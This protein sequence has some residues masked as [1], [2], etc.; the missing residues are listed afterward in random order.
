MLSLALLATFLAI[1]DDMPIPAHSAGRVTADGRFGWPGVYFEGRFTGDDVSVAVETSH[2][3]FRVLIDG[4]ERAT[5]TKAGEARVS[6]TKLGQGEHIVR[7]EKL[8]ESQEG[9]SRFLGFFTRTGHAIARRAANPRQIEFIGD[10]YTVGY[11]NISADQTCTE[12]QVHDRTD[13]QAAF[14][15]VLARRLNADYRI[16]AFSGRGI[17][18]NYSGLAPGMSLPVL[19]PRAIP[20][21]AAAAATDA[22]W[23]PQTI[24]INL[25]T[26]DFSTALK[27]GEAWKDDAA[28]RQDYRARY[29]AFV[30]ELR[31][32][33]R[34]AR[35]ILMAPERFYADVEAV[36]KA[37]GATP[38][39][40]G[41]LALTGCHGH[42][43]V[44]DDA[45]M[46]DLL[47]GV[48]GG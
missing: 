23:R 2:D 42:P 19:Y 37:T 25:G 48:I 41:P 22:A 1:P 20:G 9:S 7:L 21:E 30:K 6:F 10:S 34:Q 40:F 17:V 32:R 8:T 4:K 36:A 29:V 24:V 39:K 47:F 5:L 3:H 12:Q 14:G 38:V 27:P 28:L 35:V 13:T 46:A 44:K 16:V 26:N 15:P 45:A 43:S 33:Q 11:G 18:R 31:A